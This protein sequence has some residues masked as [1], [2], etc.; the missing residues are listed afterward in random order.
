[1]VIPLGVTTLGGIRFAV[2]FA[3][4]FAVEVLFISIT[5]HQE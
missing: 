2:W 5:R 1:M 3:A 4:I